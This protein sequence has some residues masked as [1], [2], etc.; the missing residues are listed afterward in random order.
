M[1][2]LQLPCPAPFH[3]RDVVFSHGWL[4]LAPYTWDPETETLTRVE[5]LPSGA[6]V[7]LQLSASPGGVLMETDAEPE[8]LALLTGRARWVLA[9]DDDFS[10]FHQLCRTDPGLRATAE[11]GQ[12]RILRSPTVWEDLVKT[13]FSVNTTWRQTVAMTRGLV[14]RHGPVSP[15]G[16]RAFPEPASVAACDPAVLQETCRLGYRAEPL[17]L[18]ARGISEGRVD[19]EALKDP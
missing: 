9:L 12:G 7:R 11:R 18:L 15:R 3:F 13:L 17:V 4:R 8:Y 5:R 14:E 6:V 2:A 1:L 19:L 16:D 10:A